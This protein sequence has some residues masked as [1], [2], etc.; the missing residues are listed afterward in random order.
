MIDWSPLEAFAGL[1]TRLKEL[2]MPSPEWQH[3]RQSNFTPGCVV[4]RMAT[5]RYDVCMKRRQKKKTP[6]GINLS[7][8][9]SLTC[10]VKPAVNIAVRGKHW[11]WN[12]PDAYGFGFSFFLFDRVCDLRS[13]TEREVQRRMRNEISDL[14]KEK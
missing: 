14:E 3:W 2:S 12:T 1:S 8:G 9:Y 7:R 10:Q 4:E 11:T 5:Y 6:D 13:A